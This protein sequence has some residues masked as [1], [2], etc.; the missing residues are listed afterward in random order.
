MIKFP[1]TLI[2]GGARSGKSIFAEQMAEKSDKKLIYIATAE[3]HDHEMVNR[4][5]L[6]Q[7]RRCDRWRTIEEPYNIADMIGEH[8][9][10]EV[11][12]LIDC[13]TLWLSNLMCRSRD[14]MPHFVSLISSLENVSGPVMLVANEVGLSIVPENN[15]ARAFRDEAGRL[16]KA[17]ASAASDVIFMAAGLPMSLKKDGKVISRHL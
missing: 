4:I 7:S 12:L 16:N 10:P 14:L 13:L 2:L 11:I 8:A 9:D 3:A 15:L 6:H 1:I 5:T 17:V